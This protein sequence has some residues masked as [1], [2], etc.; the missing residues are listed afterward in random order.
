MAGEINTNASWTFRPATNNVATYMHCQQHVRKAFHS[1]LRSGNVPVLKGSLN[2]CVLRLKAGIYNLILKEMGLLAHASS[3][4]L[5]DISYLFRWKSVLTNKNIFVWVFFYICP[6]NLIL[7]CI[8]TASNM[9]NMSPWV[10]TLPF[11]NPMKLWQFDQQEFVPRQLSQSWTSPCRRGF[12]SS[13]FPYGY[14]NSKI[15][16]SRILFER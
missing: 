3:T 8:H 16:S 9:I 1:Q 15:Q 11:R 7:Q 6:W 13:L 2:A 14:D 4:S 10:H 12:S 5:R